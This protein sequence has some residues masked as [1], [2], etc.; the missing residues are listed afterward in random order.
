MT[1]SISSAMRALAFSAALAFSLPAMAH[2][3]KLGDLEI[4]HPWSKEA[5]LGAKVAGGY[6]VVKNHGA[7]AEKLI[8]ASGEIAGKAEIHDMS[9]DANGVMTMRQM[10]DGVEIPAGGEL[11]LAPGGKH[12]MF[13]ELNRV[14]K[15]GEKFKGSLT[16]E[17]AGKVELEFAVQKPKT[18]SAKDG[19]HK[20]HLMWLDHWDGA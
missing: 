17:K 3:Y 20:H 2:E 11:E 10:A 12:I 9:V 1:F 6:V 5:P 13:M 18:G 4:I 8:G 14:P 15:D 7:T 16:F 19:E